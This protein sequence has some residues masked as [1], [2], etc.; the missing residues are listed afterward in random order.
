M[1]GEDRGLVQR[2]KEGRIVVLHCGRLTNGKV[3]WSRDTNGQRVDILTTHNEQT[4]KHIADPDRR[5]GS[6]ANLVLTI[7]RVSQSDAGRY[8]CSAATVELS[9]TAETLHQTEKEG[10]NVTLKCGRLT[11]GTVTWSRD[12]NGQRVDILTTHNGETTKHIADPDR[13]YGSRKDPVLIIHGVSQSDA[14]RYDCSGATVELSV[15]SGTDQPSTTPTTQRKTTKA[16]ETTTTATTP[17]TQRR[18]TKAT[19]TTTTATTPTTQRRNTKATETTTTATTPKT[20]RRT[21]KATETTTATTPTTQRRTTKAT[22]TA[23]A[24]ESSSGGTTRALWK[25]LIIVAVSCLVAVALVLFLWKCFYKRKVCTVKQKQDHLY[26]CID[27][28]MPTT[29][30][31]SDEQNAKE[32]VYHLVTQPR[33]QITDDQQSTPEAAEPLGNNPTQTEQ[34]EQLYAKIKKP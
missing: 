18:N 22:E 3:T 9:V 21:T 8:D 12:T 26:D 34:V 7:F 23:T 24:T 10:N 11:N 14:G 29:Q 17:T 13:R 27:N 16:T 28:N 15:T 25:V 33:V 20:Q 1:R 4:T 30:P 19:E 5:Y 6:G 31:A 32:P 2:Q